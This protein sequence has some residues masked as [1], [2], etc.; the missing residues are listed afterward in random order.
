MTEI[1]GRGKSAMPHD[2]N[3]GHMT[4]RQHP[5]ADRDALQ[6]EAQQW[7]MRLTSGEATA[8]DAE[9]LNRWRLTSRAHRQAFAEANLLWDKLRPAAAETGIRSAGSPQAVPA[10][11]FLTG[12]RAFLGGALAATAAAATYV[13]VRP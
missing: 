1:C 9:A 6:R 8:A 11:G 7:V 12:R 13:V 10:T 3:I 2:G 4:E 5:P